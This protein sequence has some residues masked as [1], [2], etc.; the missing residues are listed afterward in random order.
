MKQSAMVVEVITLRRGVRTFNEI[1]LAGWFPNSAPLVGFFL[2]NPYHA[3]GGVHHIVC[4]ASDT[5]EM[6][7]SLRFP[8][9]MEGHLGLRKFYHG[10]KLPREKITAGKNYRVFLP[11]RSNFFP[12]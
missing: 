3:K 11:I 9:K 5:T 4:D 8:K 12:R 2:R 1:N 6:G 10:K 7:G